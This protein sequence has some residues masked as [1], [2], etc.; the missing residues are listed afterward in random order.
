[1]SYFRAR[2]NF[3]IFISIRASKWRIE[4][5]LLSNA[6]KLTGQW[7]E[8]F[9]NVSVTAA[10]HRSRSCNS[11][12]STHH[13]RQGWRTWWH[14]AWG[15]DSVHRTPAT[16]EEEISAKTTKSICRAIRISRMVNKSLPKVSEWH[17]LDSWLWYFVSRYD[18][19]ISLKLW[20]SI[21]NS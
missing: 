8:Q 19:V 2:F 13:P 21:M 4:Q 20:I 14:N 16:N 12:H 18:W 15:Q 11:T 1:M 17:R 3:N 9:P 10:R 7:V 5:T 6:A